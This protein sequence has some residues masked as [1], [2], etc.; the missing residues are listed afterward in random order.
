M[1]DD[2]SLDPLTTTTTTIEDHNNKGKTYNIS[3]GRAVLV[4]EMVENT[5]KLSNAVSTQPTMPSGPT[6]PSILL[7]Y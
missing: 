6:H 3:D 4:D 2:L 7:E 1:E 5:V